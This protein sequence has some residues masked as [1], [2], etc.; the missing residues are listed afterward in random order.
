MGRPAIDLSGQRFGRLRVICR[1]GNATNGAALWRCECDCGAI[2]RVYGNNLA[3]LKTSSCGCLKLELTVAKGHANR[4]HGGDGTPEY[5][6]WVAMRSRCYRVRD[7]SYRHYGGRGIEVCEEWRNSFEA[8][9]A[10]VGLRPS[11]EHSLERL[12]VNEN[13]CPGNVCWATMLEQNRNRRDNRRI[14]HDGET[15]TL[16]QWAE[17]TGLGR[18]TIAYRINQ[19]WSVSDALSK[20]PRYGVSPMHKMFNAKN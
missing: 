20:E 8:F 14:E 5:R 7:P 10:C 16:S 2:T 3:S 1:D 11:P 18:A 6:A 9:I 4:R 13:Y 19:G 15:L 17:R 12:R